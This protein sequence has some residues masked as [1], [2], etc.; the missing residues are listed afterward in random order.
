MSDGATAYQARPATGPMKDYRPPEAPPGRV[1]RP[2]VTVPQPIPTQTKAKESGEDMT[3]KRSA[4]DTEA[5]REAKVLDVVKLARPYAVTNR[6]LHTTTDI[7]LSTLRRI[8]RTLCDRGELVQERGPQSYLF[9]LPEPETT[10]QHRMVVNTDDIAPD[11]QLPPDMVASIAAGSV[12]DAARRAMTEAEKN[13]DKLEA[14]AGGSAG[15]I[16]PLPADDERITALLSLKP[17]VAAS[18]AASIDS[19][20]EHVTGGSYE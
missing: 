18:V 2:V 7:P 13:L 8:T 15:S 1:H 11:D 4:R 17:V 9:R 6:E 16:E 20:L 3:T 5:L 14:L 19:L 10:H 12:A